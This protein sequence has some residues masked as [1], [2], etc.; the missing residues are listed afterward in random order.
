MSIE[1]C[2]GRLCEWFLLK[3]E[4]DSVYLSAALVIYRFPGVWNELAINKTQ[5]TW[6]Q[7]DCIAA[8]MSSQINL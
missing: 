2:R 3:G 6:L 7:P 1:A 4:N 5:G 8:Y